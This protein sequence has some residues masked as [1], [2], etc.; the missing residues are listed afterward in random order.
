MS[1]DVNKTVIMTHS[2]FEAY[3]ESVGNTTD[4]LVDALELGDVMLVTINEGKTPEH[5]NVSVGVSAAIS[6]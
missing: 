3:R 1:I 4:I 2:Q 5:L 6:A